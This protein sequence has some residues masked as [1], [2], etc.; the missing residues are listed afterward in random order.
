MPKYKPS[1]FFCLSELLTSKCVTSATSFVWGCIFFF[2]LSFLCVHACNGGM[3]IYC[4]MLLWM[5]PT[6]KADN[7]CVGGWIGHLTEAP[8]YRD[9]FP[10]NN[11]DFPLSV[12]Q[13]TP[14]LHERGSPFFIKGT[15]NGFFLFQTILYRTNQKTYIRWTGC[16]YT[17]RRDTCWCTV[18][19]G[20][21]GTVCSHVHVNKSH[22]C[23][24]IMIVINLKHLGWEPL[25][26]ILQAK[27]I[28][29]SKNQDHVCFFAPLLLLVSVLHFEILMEMNSKY[30]H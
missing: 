9:F 5:L 8:F 4:K 30:S 29:C 12:R 17:A 23:G 2:S 16:V 14:K 6:V 18:C 1:V 7:I 19:H 21:F 22:F 11:P 24:E 10:P 26:T 13:L 20:A 28:P 3:W 25:A 27:W 15:R